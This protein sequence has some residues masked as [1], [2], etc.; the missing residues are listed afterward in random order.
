RLALHPLPVLGSKAV[1]GGETI[2]VAFATEDERVIRLAQ[3][4]CRLD[5]GVEHG[6]QIE[7]RAAD[8]LEHVRSGGLLLQRLALLVEQ[9][10]V[11]D[12]NPRLVGEGGYEFDLPT[13]EWPH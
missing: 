13:S 6:L 9:A 2:T 7:C 1:T 4:C 5:Q 3:A 12:P 8:D 11:L 10:R